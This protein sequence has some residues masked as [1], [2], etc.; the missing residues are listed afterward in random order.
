MTGSE[1]AFIYSQ[2]SCQ[3]AVDVVPDHVKEFP[4]VRS[5]DLEISAHLLRGLRLF[6]QIDHHFYQ[7]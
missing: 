5:Q 2:Q 3:A 4:Q 6:Q 7:V 1:D